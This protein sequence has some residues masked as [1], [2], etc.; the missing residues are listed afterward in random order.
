[1]V[2]SFLECLN[3]TEALFLWYIKHMTFAL[4]LLLPHDEGPRNPDPGWKCPGGT[5]DGIHADPEEEGVVKQRIREKDSE[6]SRNLN[7]EQ[8][9]GKRK[10]FSSGGDEVSKVESG[11]DGP[12]AEWKNK[13]RGQGGEALINAEVETAEDALEESRSEQT[14]YVLGR[15][16]PSQEGDEQP[17]RLYTVFSVRELVPY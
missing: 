7:P 13:R 3:K 12:A 1:M 6:P 17:A 2:K 9:E 14:G 8:D 16:W 4:I 11:T 10:S 5:V 15:T